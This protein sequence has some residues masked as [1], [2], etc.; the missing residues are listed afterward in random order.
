MVPDR[1]IKLKWTIRQF[2]VGDRANLIAA[3]DAVCG[4]EQWMCTRNFEPTPDWTHAL[5][6]VGCLR[7][8]LL[9]VEA[10]PTVIGWCRTF[11]I[12]PCNGFQPEANLGIGLL[13]PYRNMGIGTALVCESL[14]WALSVGMRNVTLATRVDNARAI[15]VFEKRGFRATG[16][17]PDALLKMECKLYPLH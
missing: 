10:G 17:T 16:D 7:H 14:Q 1:R 5:V 2:A 3:I 6:Q 12:Y 4:E 11:P 9:V 15:H 8:L 13:E